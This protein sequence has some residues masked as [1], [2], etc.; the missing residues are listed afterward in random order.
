MSAANDWTLVAPRAKRAQN[1]IQI[2]PSQQDI[3]EKSLAKPTWASIAK[4][5]PVQSTQ[6][7]QFMQPLGSD[8]LTLI[9]D[10]LDALSVLVFSIL[11]RHPSFHTW[12]AS[13]IK[14]EVNNM[15]MHKK[16]PNCLNEA[17]RAELKDEYSKK[18][19]GWV[20][21]EGKLKD[22]LV[23]D[24]TSLPRLWKLNRKITIIDSVGPKTDT[25]F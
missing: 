2:K 19:I 14:K 3:A 13:A 10:S 18:D 22:Y 16:L 12:P 11:Y 6:L 4:S 5:V 9:I 20:L 23:C 15:I 24:Q 25:T 17:K 7:T 8:H 1:Q 21:Y